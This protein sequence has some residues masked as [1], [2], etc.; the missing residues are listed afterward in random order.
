MIYTEL[1]AKLSSIF[2]ATAALMKS[3]PKCDLMKGKE[4]EVDSNALCVCVRAFAEI[5]CRRRS[6][7]LSK[8]RVTKKWLGKVVLVVVVVAW[9]TA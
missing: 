4:R 3:L 1:V 9:Q 6:L 5:L 2:A 7:A 8:K